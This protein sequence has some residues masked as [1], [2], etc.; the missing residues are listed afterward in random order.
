MNF[1]EISSHDK[2]LSVLPVSKEDRQ[3]IKYLVMATKNG[4]VKK[5]PLKDFENVRRNGLIA[6]NLKS[7][8]ALCSARK[9]GDGEEIIQ[10][11]VR[12]PQTNIFRPAHELKGFTKVALAPGASCT[13]MIPFGDHA[14]TYYNPDKRQWCTEPGAYTIEVGASSR[15]IRIT[16]SVHLEGKAATLYDEDQMNPYYTGDVQQV[17]DSAFAA[18]LGRPIPVH[19]WSNASHLTRDDTISQLRYR[20]GP[21][22]LPYDVLRFI[23]WLLI[24]CNRPH[25]ANNLMFVM[26]MPFAKIPGFTGGRLSERIIKVLLRLGE[27]NDPPQ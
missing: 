21:T 11:Y 26:N 1:L 14:F 17:R 6:I 4:I 5:T 22:R 8:D 13:V 19:R 3:N 25:M 20:H 7:G 23:R 10:V 12:P 9:A 24:K 18:L 15:D 16:A 2:I 27:P